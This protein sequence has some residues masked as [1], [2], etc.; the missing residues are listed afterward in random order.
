MKPMNIQEVINNILSVD[1]QEACL[2]GIASWEI[3]P[4]E[5]LEALEDQCT[6]VLFDLIDNE[7]FDLPI[8]LGV[9]TGFDM[10]EE[11][12]AIQERCFSMGKLISAREISD[13]LQHKKPVPTPP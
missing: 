10:T 2:D 12:I 5:E 4:D 1:T 13:L 11:Y 8:I 3:S 9:N 7:A 6:S